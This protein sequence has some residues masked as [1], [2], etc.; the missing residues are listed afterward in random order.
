MKILTPGHKYEL[1]NFENPELAGQVLQF[2][3]KQPVGDPTGGQLETVNAE[4][5]E[6]A[7]KK[8]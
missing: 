7:D 1:A 6:A 5:S 4:V 8:R 3:E 2:I